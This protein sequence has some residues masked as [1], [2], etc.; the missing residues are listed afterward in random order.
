[1]QRTI[2]TFGVISGLL[3]IGI[4]ILSF[5]LSLM[6]AWFG[7][8][9]MFIAFAA[10]FVAIRQYR[11]QQL[12]GTIRFGTALRVGLGIT[13]VASLVYVAVWEVYLHFTGSAFIDAYVQSMIDTY[14]ADGMKGAPLEA[15]IAEAQAMKT[16]YANPLFRLPM[17]LLEIFPV[18]ALTSL[19]AAAVLRNNKALPAS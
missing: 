12:G 16:Q 15:A 7:F 4:I 10:I 1:M 14:M 9:V 19:V 18:G 8:L 6:E 5:S 3:I 17:T 13:L 11:D 2:L